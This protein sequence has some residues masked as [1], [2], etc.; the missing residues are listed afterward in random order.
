M[1]T[2]TPAVKAFAESVTDGAR[3]ST[4]RPVIEL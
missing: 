4:R 1:N 2:R 3:H